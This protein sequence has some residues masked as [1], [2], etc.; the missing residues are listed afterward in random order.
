[1]AFTQIFHSQSLMNEIQE[2]QIYVI[3]ANFQNEKDLHVTIQW[4]ANWIPLIYRLIIDENIKFAYEVALK[5]LGFS[6][7]MYTMV[8]MSCFVTYV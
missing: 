7:L 1:M 2:S 6:V 8:Y 3:I 5:G 4:N